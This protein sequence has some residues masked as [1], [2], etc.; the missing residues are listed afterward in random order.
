MTAQLPV[1][2]KDLTPD[3]RRDLRRAV[4]AAT[5]DAVAKFLAP[6]FP[7]G[8]A[9]PIAD[10]FVYESLLGAYVIE[11]NPYEV[12]AED[13]RP[14]I[15]ADHDKEGRWVR[16]SG[17]LRDNSVFNTLDLLEPIPAGQPFQFVFEDV[18]HLEDDLEVPENKPGPAPG[19][20]VLPSDGIRQYAHNV[21]K[22]VR[23]RYAIKT[24]KP[25]PDD[26]F[27]RG[28]ILLAYSGGDSSG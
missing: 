19:P 6:L 28:F 23:L 26:H 17:V 1:R 11:Q 3:Q 15:P 16:K 25:M 5:V 21:V 4:D 10:E 14:I 22:I 8:D 24:R 12:L 18:P 9:G 27:Q 2:R 7:G 20:G 13:A